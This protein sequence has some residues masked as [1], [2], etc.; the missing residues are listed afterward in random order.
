MKASQALPPMGFETADLM[1]V[2]GH[3]LGAYSCG[4]VVDDYRAPA[5]ELGQ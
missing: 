5:Q 1:T 3:R 4:R 2:P